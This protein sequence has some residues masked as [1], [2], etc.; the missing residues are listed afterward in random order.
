MQGIWKILQVEAT[1]EA[2]LFPGKTPEEVAEWVFSWME[3]CP[4]APLPSMLRHQQLAE[5]KESFMASAVPEAAA[6]P[7]REGAIAM[8][9]V[10]LWG[11]GTV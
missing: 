4:A 5:L 3:R 10:M 7:S 9:T 6:L 1:K 11:V 8:E 2:K